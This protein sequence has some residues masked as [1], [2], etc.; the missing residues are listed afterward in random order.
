PCGPVLHRRR[1]DAIRADGARRLARPQRRAAARGRAGLQRTAATAEGIGLGAR[2]GYADA[3]AVLLG[4]V[5]LG[6]LDRA[7][8]LH[9][10]VAVDRSGTRGDRGDAREPRASGGQEEPLRAASD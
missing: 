2:M 8:R 3:G 9:G 5:L 1:R 10:D 4:A 7:P 6:A